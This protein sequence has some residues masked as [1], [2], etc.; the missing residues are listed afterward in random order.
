MDEVILTRYPADRRGG[1]C[2][3]EG[4]SFIDKPVRTGTV[5]ENADMG[6]DERYPWFPLSPKYLDTGRYVRR[7]RIR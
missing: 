3:R 5:P 2:G 4:P 1:D 6:I 7:A